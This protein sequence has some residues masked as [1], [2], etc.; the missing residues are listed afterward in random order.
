MRYNHRVM[1]QTDFENGS[2]PMNIL[3]TAFPMFVAQV[4]N[5]LYSIVDR[6]YIGRIPGEGTIALGS[7]YNYAAYRTAGA[8]THG[9]PRAT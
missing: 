8:K 1:R 3:Q 7:I 6:I 5:L 4:L 2:T 9:E